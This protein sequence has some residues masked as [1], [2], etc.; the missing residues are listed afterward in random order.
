M[1]M[2]VH[3]FTPGPLPQNTD[4]L[5]YVMN[6]FPGYRMPY[7]C[8]MQT[9]S[10]HLAGG[11][12]CVGMNGFTPTAAATALGGDFVGNFDFPMIYDIDVSKV[13]AR[14]KPQI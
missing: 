11:D 2:Y 3:P 7:L 1:L 9:L 14:Y 5:A 12:D 8:E 4:K 6:N 10:R 13:S